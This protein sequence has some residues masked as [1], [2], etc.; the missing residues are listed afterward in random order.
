VFYRE[1]NLL[2]E[3]H[4]VS[5]TFSLLFA[6]LFP[7]L[8]KG[9]ETLAFVFNII[10]LPFTLIHELGHYFTIL[11]LFPD[12][13]PHLNL[14]PF[15]EGLVSGT[16]S[17]SEV[18]ISWI[19]TFLFFIGSGTVIIFV[20]ISIFLVRRKNNSN[21]NNNSS[22]IE[23]YLIFGLLFDIPN[24]FPI[25]PSNGIVTDGFRAWINLHVLA[26]F[27]FPSIQFSYLFIGIASVVTFFSLFY[28]G[29]SIYHIFTL[30]VFKLQ[31]HSE[32][33]LKSTNM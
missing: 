19:S 13:N 15:E 18:D 20:L 29:S 3:D 21:N 14:F 17:L 32:F 7:F 25:F 4:K 24:L 23:K 28:L 2:L 27:P 16:V 11:L 6:I 5:F 9:F 26:N 33:P 30:S 12:Q 8:M 10:F 31:N 22:L 1:N